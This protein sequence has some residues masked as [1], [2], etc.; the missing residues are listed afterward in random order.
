MKR[1]LGRVSGSQN[2][3]GMEGTKETMGTQNGK[4]SDQEVPISIAI[5][6]RTLSQSAMQSGQSIQYGPTSAENKSYACPCWAA[7]SQ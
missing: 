7:H 6:E 4:S 5:H 1:E 3:M 2:G